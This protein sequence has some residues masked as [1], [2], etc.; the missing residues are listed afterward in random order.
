VGLTDP[1][2]LLVDCPHVGGAL[3]FPPGS[4]P[5]FTQLRGETV[6]KGIRGNAPAMGLTGIRAIERAERYLSAPRRPA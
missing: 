6:R 4:A 2:R 5:L 1:R 3:A